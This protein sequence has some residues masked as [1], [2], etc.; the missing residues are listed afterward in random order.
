MT[1]PIPTPR[2]AQKWWEENVTWEP[3]DHGRAAFFEGERIVR[4][5]LGDGRPF[6]LY[7][8]VPGSLMDAGRSKYDQGRDVYLRISRWQA[9]RLG[10]EWRP[11]PADEQT[12]NQQEQHMGQEYPLDNNFKHHAPKGDQ[13]ER[14][15]ALRDKAKELA[16]LYLELVPPSRERSVALTNLE[17]AVFWANAGIA[18][19]ESEPKP[20]PVE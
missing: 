14:Y 13:Q 15:T 2:A 18:R 5:Y 7:K 9:E 17:Q 10:V 20:A 16:A 1:G 12:N 11:H 6:M 19:N 3:S 4:D 8:L